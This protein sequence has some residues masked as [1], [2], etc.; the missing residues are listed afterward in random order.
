MGEILATLSLGNSKIEA[1]ASKAIERS[2]LGSFNLLAARQVLSELLGA[3]GST[4][5]FATYTKHDISHIDALLEAADWVIPESTFEKLTVADALVITLAIYVH[6]LGML[7]TKNEFAKRASSDFP[8]FKSE[9]MADASSQGVDLRDRLAA[10]EPEDQEH[11]LYEEFVR[12]HHAERAESWVS[13]RVQKN[14]GISEEAFEIVAKV[15]EPLDNVLRSDI[16]LIARSHH[17]DDLDNLSKY[18][19]NRS[20]GNAADESANLQYAAIILRSVDLLHMTRD[21]T[22]VVQFR[23]ASP[24]DPMGQRE[25]QKQQAVRAV[26]A[27]ATAGEQSD[28]IEIHA[29][30]E[31]A[32]GFFALME[33]IEYCEQQLRMSAAWADIASSQSPHLSHYRFPWRNIDREQ[34]EAEGFDR[35]QFAFFFDQER[36]LELLTGHTLYNDAGVAVR[37]LVQNAIDAVR[38]GKSKKLTQNHKGAEIKV[39]YDSDSRTLSILDHGVGMS[40]ETIQEHFL[41]VGS[42]SYQTKDFVEKNPKFTSIS[43][44]GIGVLSAFMIADEVRVATITSDEHVGRELVLKSVHG[45]YLIKEFSST[46]EYADRIG[47][48]GTEIELKLRASSDLQFT[49]LALL[50]KWVLLP[51]CKVTCVEDGAAPIQVGSATVIDA[52]T[53]LISFMPN[54]A[55]TRVIPFKRDGIDVAVAQVWSEAYKE[56]E[57]LRFGRSANGFED[58]RIH[59]GEVRPPISGVSVQGIRVTEHLPGF[60]DGGPVMLVNVSGPKAPKTNVARSDMEAGPALD[61]LTRTVYSA[62]LDG[63]ECQ[64]PEM[65]KRI[66]M[67][68]ALKEASHIYNAGVM[69]ERGTLFSKPL[70]LNSVLRKSE[71]HPVE[72]GGLLEAKSCDDLGATGFS[73]LVGPAADD[74]ARFLDWLPK[75]KGLLTLLQDGGLLEDANEVQKP[76]LGGQ[77][78][79]FAYGALLWHEFEPAGIRLLER[80]TSLFL[81]FETKETRWIRLKEY[82]QEFIA[83]YQSLTE[84]IAR[85]NRERFFNRSAAPLTSRFCIDPSV[86][87]AGLEDFD[88]FVINGHRMF[89]AHSQYSIVA[90]RIFDRLNKRSD[91]AAIEELALL[92]TIS[93]RVQGWK[94]DEETQRGFEEGVEAWIGSTD[95]SH[96]VEREKLLELTRSV[97]AARTWT[98]AG[99]WQRRGDPEQ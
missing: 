72:V 57:V 19:T 17:L 28:S 1:L 15:F 81:T 55:E 11:F 32:E 58:P 47:Q 98:S 70:L 20:Y 5:E 45:R 16:A 68:L 77:Q 31:K 80:G 74:A 6:D 90:K 46:S 22:P 9:I 64:I 62:L 54:G 34:I 61:E 14:L 96:W 27:K 56:W 78:A 94:E 43:R 26:K 87:S 53:E 93:D 8:H 21:R 73:V 88:A 67:R 42:S 23:L 51:E 92:L 50:Q 2:A 99:A 60:Q 82:S 65:T 24:S 30:F 36:V 10:L 63:I 83:H 35:R 66:S 48:H 40:Q 59:S 18:K 76:L 85:T 38:L 91:L 79:L 13:G 41:K 89:L 95:R 3:I 49:I 86:V 29:R 7:V 44:F 33:Y 69:G 97:P 25:W 75:P 12:V 39:S 84:M 71:L 37:E 52:L 4:A